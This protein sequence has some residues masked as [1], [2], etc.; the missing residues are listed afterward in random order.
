MSVRRGKI[1]IGQGEGSQLGDLLLILGLGTCCN[2]TNESF[3][4]PLLPSYSHLELC[5]PIRYGAQ[6]LQAPLSR[7]QI[8]THEQIDQHLYLFI[9]DLVLQE[10]LIASLQAQ[11]SEAFDALVD[12]C[13]LNVEVLVGKVAARGEQCEEGLNQ[14]LSAIDV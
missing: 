12:G 1:K 8:L 6:Y 2:K 4:A 3:N 10:L 14:Q 7:L 13:L 11:S 9:V 5:L